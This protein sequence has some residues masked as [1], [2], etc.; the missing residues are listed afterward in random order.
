MRNL[1][2]EPGRDDLVRMLKED[3]LEWLVQTMRPRTIYPPARFGGLN[4]RTRLR[5]SVLADG[6]IHPDRVRE[7]VLKPDKGEQDFVK[8]KL[9]K[10]FI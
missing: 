5:N 2:F 4:A 7:I 6:K 1:F 8:T 10:H 9:W 3:L